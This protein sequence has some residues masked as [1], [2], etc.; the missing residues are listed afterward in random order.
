MKD[1]TELEAIQAL[2]D[3]TSQHSEP[4]PNTRSSIQQQDENTPTTDC[5]AQDSPLSS[6]V[7]RKPS[8]SSSPFDATRNISPS[9]ASQNACFYPNGFLDNVLPSSLTS[10]PDVPLVPSLMHPP[11]LAPQEP[12]VD[13]TP[14]SPALCR[15]ISCFDLVG[16][17]GCG[18]YGKVLLGNIS[19]GSTG[20]SSLH[21][22]KV[23][24][25][26]DMHRDGVEEVKRELRALRWIAD[27]VNY[28]G[29][30]R[31]P[32]NSSVM[33]LQKMSESFQNENFVFIVLEYHPVSLAHPL[34]AARLRLH[35]FSLSS[36]AN[37]SISKSKSL[38]ASFSSLSVDLHSPSGYEE[39]LVSFNSL[40]L[41]AAELVMGLIFLHQSGIVHQDIKPANIMISSAGHVVIADF[42]ASTALPFSFDYEDF[43]VIPT[44]RAQKT[45][46][47]I[48]LNP[49]NLI[50]F[51]PLYAAPELVC[52]NRAG[53]II[54]DSRVDWWSL[55]VVL[56]ELATGSAPF[57]IPLTTKTKGKVQPSADEPKRE[58]MKRRSLGDFSLTFGAMEKLLADMEDDD[59]YHHRELV[60]QLQTFIRA[61]LV[62]HVSDRLSG[63]DVKNHPFFEPISHLWNEIAALAH[64][65]LPGPPE[66][67]LDPDTSLDFALSP[68]I[69][70][71]AYNDTSSFSQS[72]GDGDE[73][74]PCSASNHQNSPSSLKVT[75]P[76]SRKGVLAD[77]PIYSP[78]DTSNHVSTDGDSD[79]GPSLRK[80]VSTSVH[81][82]DEGP[83]PFTHSDAESF[84]DPEEEEK[85][86]EDGTSSYASPLQPFPSTASLHDAPP[87]QEHAKR[88]TGFDSESQGAPNIEFEA[89]IGGDDVEDVELWNP[90]I[91]RP[92]DGPMY[93]SESFASTLP[94]PYSPQPTLAHR[95]ES[96]HDFQSLHCMASVGTQPE[97]GLNL[98]ATPESADP[99]VVEDV[100]MEAAN[101]GIASVSDTTS[102]PSLREG[103][104]IPNTESNLEGHRQLPMMRFKS[105][106]F[107]SFSPLAKKEKEI[108]GEDLLFFSANTQPRR[109]SVSIPLDK[110]KIE[111]HKGHRSF[112]R[113]SLSARLSNPKFVNT[114]MGAS[115]PT[116]DGVKLEGPHSGSITSKSK[117]ERQAKKRFSFPTSS[118]GS[119]SKQEK[120][121]QQEQRQTWNTRRFS[122][123]MPLQ[124]QGPP[125]SFNAA[126]MKLK[127]KSY[128]LLNISR[129]RSRPTPGNE[130]APSSTAF[131]PALSPTTAGADGCAGVSILPFPEH[132]LDRMRIEYQK[133]RATDPIPMSCTPRTR[134]SNAYTH[135][136]T[137]GRS[138]GSKMIAQAQASAIAMQHGYQSEQGAHRAS[139]I[140]SSVR[141]GH[142]HSHSQSSHNSAGRGDWSPSLQDELTIAVLS[143]MESKGSDSRD[144]TTMNTIRSS[145]Y[146]SKAR[147]EISAPIRAQ[148]L[149]QSSQ[150][151]QS[152]KP[153]PA[154]TSSTLTRT[155]RA[156]WAGIVKPRRSISH[157]Q[158][159][160]VEQSTL[161]ACSNLELQR[162]PVVPVGE[163][164][165]TNKSR[166]GIRSA[167]VHAEE[168]KVGSRF[169]DPL[170]RLFTSENQFESQR[171]QRPDRG[172]RQLHRE[173]PERRSLGSRFWKKFKQ[174]TSF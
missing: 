96:T 106:P 104:E 154:A 161:L 140:A 83:C 144:F 57:T 138:T 86:T 160:D 90:W 101:E 105:D 84:H 54:Y 31:Q 130:K 41:I 70:G 152:E 39:S 72:V 11:I 141:H 27:T 33:F 18:S 3:S 113:F 88:C 30:T 172:I 158:V 173:R 151:R 164:V 157:E 136:A 142:S 21:A 8:Y 45:F 46:H 116:V 147:M 122:A 111:R 98:Y 81:T 76:V 134:V 7:M 79:L 145:T 35:A 25:K 125:S 126:K 69:C 10:T 2:L 102:V 73:Q 139:S 92:F 13:L 65:P 155:H 71:P 169:E 162:A 75:W 60:S 149:C 114:S 6:S 20:S 49:H 118:F 100:R 159:T 110:D 29:A 5:P 68:R 28:A 12:L 52:R 168:E 153:Q 58:K 55:G 109:K 115:R 121:E 63:Q 44:S 67:S 93:P 132:E 64:P 36:E 163:T 94:N 62:D 133:R 97:L 47:P 34:A 26:R 170:H 128:S 56:Y 95:L 137:L 117:Q 82:L 127:E 19:N 129:S 174:L 120:G 108:E 1:F 42:N 37:N 14:P 50:T 24:R 15:S 17:I 53:L 124:S 32:Q 66:V 40:Q 85:A 91:P 89:D 148:S 38:P 99:I 123:P 107:T 22:I 131:S 165:K 87:A 74:S 135:A 146:R 156:S 77:D 80:T 59:H 4:S 150:N 143:A 166:N 16:T 23:L 167:E 48:V 78:I 119:E 51:T 43:P 9:G 112:S 171:S 61:L 103:M